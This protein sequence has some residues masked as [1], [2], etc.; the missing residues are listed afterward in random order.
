MLQFPKIE[1][2][3]LSKIYHQDQSSNEIFVDVDSAKK[4]FMTDEAIETFNKY[5]YRQEWKLINDN[6]SLH[7]TITFELDTQSTDTPN[8]DKW[9]DTKAGMTENRKWFVEE[10]WPTIDHD[11]KHL[12]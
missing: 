8:S 9:R 5:S 10:H 2:N 11:A 1:A 4:F 12:F 3:K 7:W 6:K